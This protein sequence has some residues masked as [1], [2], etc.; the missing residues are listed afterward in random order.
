MARLV[1]LV[2]AIGMLFP[3]AAQAGRMDIDVHDDFF[4]PDVVGNQVGDTVRWFSD[5]TNSN[6]HN[7]RE[8]GLLFRN[9]DPTSAAF[10]YDVVFSAGTFHYYCE[11]H[12]SEFG[13]MDGLVRIPVRLNRAPDGLPFTVRWASAASETGSVYDVQFRVGS[14]DWRNWR[15]DTTTL[16]GVFGRNRNPVRVRDGVLYSFRA[17]SQ[18]GTADSRYSP[19]RSFR[20]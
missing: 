8:D 5:G 4:A 13:G 9:G 10:T 12:G 15:T 17:R 6:N 16:S 3:S 14:G 11:V 2:L 19:V 18:E 7:V 20:P 1:P